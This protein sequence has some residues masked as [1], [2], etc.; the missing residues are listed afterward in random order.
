MQMLKLDLG[1][2]DVV[3]PRQEAFTERCTVVFLQG[4]ITAWT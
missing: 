4:L 2:A 3:L 1:E